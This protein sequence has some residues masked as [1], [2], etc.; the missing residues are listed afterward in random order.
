MMNFQR[1]DNDLTYHQFEKVLDFMTYMT[2]VSPL[3]GE[4]WVQ[5]TVNENLSLLAKNPEFH[6]ARFQ[7]SRC[8]FD[9]FK[10]RVLEGNKEVQAPGEVAG[11]GCY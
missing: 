4:M 2:Q 9:P 3:K 7:E 5:N 1:T 10:K 8:D 6:R 11:C